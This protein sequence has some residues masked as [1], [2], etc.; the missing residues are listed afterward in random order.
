MTTFTIDTDNNITAFASAEEAA[1][2]TTAPIDSFTSE[3][4]LAALAANWPMERLVAIW[5][6]LASV[7]PVKRFKN[8]NAA[9]NRIWEHIQGLGDATKPE[10]EPA[11]PKA[12]SRSVRKS[13][14]EFWWTMPAAA[15]M[16]SAAGM[17]CVCRWKTCC[18]G[19][20]LAKSR[21]WRW[22]RH[23]SRCPRSMPAKGAWW[24]CVT[25]AD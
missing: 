1:A 17:R 4:E 16:P 24:S 21:Y 5:N 11:K 23:S 22:M 9:A 13:S 18:W 12:F 7:T 14:G 19:R 25:S 6:S 15:G 20:G 2:A 8:S 3:K 10:A